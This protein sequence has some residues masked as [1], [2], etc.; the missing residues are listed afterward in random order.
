MR[1]WT[2]WKQ[3]SGDWEWVGKRER[4]TNGNESEMNWNK[5]EVN[6]NESEIG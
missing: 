5:P 3:A 1:V 2:E 6:E 4:E